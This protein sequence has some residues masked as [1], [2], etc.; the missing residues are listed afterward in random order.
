MVDCSVKKA[1]TLMDKLRLPQFP[2]EHL[3]RVQDFDMKTPKEGLMTVNDHFWGP[4]PEAAQIEFIKQFNTV[5]KVK[6]AVQMGRE[7]CLEVLAGVI[8]HMAPAGDC[9]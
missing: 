8:N 9:S 1:H 2:P 5:A 6:N 7:I 3:R 4:D